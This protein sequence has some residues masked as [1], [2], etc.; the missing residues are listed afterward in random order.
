[1]Y[2]LCVKHL[3]AHGEAY[4]WLKKMDL[5]HPCKFTLP[6]LHT[7]KGVSDTK[8]FIIDF[9]VTFFSGKAY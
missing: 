8:E 4:G 3:V 6:L 1:M 9:Q 2:K 5:N 7:L